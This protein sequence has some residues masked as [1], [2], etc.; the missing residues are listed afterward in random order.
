MD[1]EH[2]PLVDELDNTRMVPPA[3]DEDRNAVRPRPYIRSREEVTMTAYLIANPPRIRQ[4]R[5][6]RAALWPVIGV[7]TAESFPDEVGPD[8]GAENV[9]RFI[10]DRTTPGS[11]HK[12]SDADSRMELVPFDQAAYHIGT[13]GL[14]DRTIGISAATQAAKWDNLSDDYRDAMVRNMA[15]D[16]ADAARWLKAEI[17]ITVPARRITLA[18]AL[19]GYAGFLAHGDA[20]PARR[21]DP[22]KSFPWDLFLT[23]YA[24]LMAGDDPDGDLTMSDIS[25]I[26][27]KLDSIHTAVVQGATTAKNNRGVIVD[28]LI[29]VLGPKID[30]AIKVGVQGAQTAENNRDVISNR[31]QSMIDNLEAELVAAIEDDDNPD[32]LI[33]QPR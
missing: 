13:H 20:D 31:V 11:Y 24:D 19:D 29:A 23:T 2:L 21:T 33:G 6:R 15:R 7:H 9:A 12:L 1:L 4:F 5:P 28:N 16:A 30:Q 25:K 26:M 32:N 3:P 10:R 18:Q 14:N 17:G 8:T 22:G 27:T